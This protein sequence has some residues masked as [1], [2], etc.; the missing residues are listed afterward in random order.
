[1][2]VDYQGQLFLK[3]EVVFYELFKGYRFIGFFADEVFM[4]D[5]EFRRLVLLLGHSADIK[6]ECHGLK[7]FKVDLVVFEE[8]GE[9]AVLVA[10]QLIDQGLEVQDLAVDAFVGEQVAVQ[11]AVF[12][13]LADQHLFAQSEQPILQ[14]EALVIRLTLVREDKVLE[15]F[16]AQADPSSLAFEVL[17]LKEA[18]QLLIL[19]NHFLAN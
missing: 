15:L 6:H 12:E 9:S 1:M 3:E 17:L 7:L 11:H 13:Q 10:H 4:A 14:I 8:V 18:G 5:F 2:A 16:L 19:A